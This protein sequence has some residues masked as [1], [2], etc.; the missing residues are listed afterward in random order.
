MRI[1]E[2]EGL[3]ANTINMG[4]HCLARLQAL[5]EKHAVIGDV[6]GKGLFL[7]LSLSPTGRLKSL[8]RKSVFRPSWLTACLRVLSSVRLID[9]CRASTIR[10][11]FHRR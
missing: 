2:D 6:R 3:L 8:W 4:E 5:Q 9:R 7:G 1:I 10:Y 11:A